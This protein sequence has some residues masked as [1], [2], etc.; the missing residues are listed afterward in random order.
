MR[1][2]I[3][4]LLNAPKQKLTSMRGLLDACGSL[5]C[6][7]VNP[8]D[9]R[10]LDATAGEELFAC[11]LASNSRKAQYERKLRLIYDAH[12]ESVS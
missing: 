4:G 6:C 10:T 2:P 3:A 11:V 1:H 12:P 7:V 9:N 8:S 5:T